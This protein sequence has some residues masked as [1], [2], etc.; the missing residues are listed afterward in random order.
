MRMMW[1][2]FL[3]RHQ[4][5]R[6][7]SHTPLPPHG[8]PSPIH[9][10]HPPDPLREPERLEQF[11]IDVDAVGVAAHALVHNLDVW[12]RLLVVRVVD[13]DVGAAEGVVVGVGGGEAEVGDGDD[14]FTGEGGYGAGGVGGVGGRGVVGHVAG[15]GGGEGDGDG[16]GE[17]GEGEG[18]GF[19]VCGWGLEGDLGCDLESD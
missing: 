4:T 12:V 6:L 11:D 15:V 3:Q 2:P 14:G 7:E 1:L 18:A 17:G 8:I 13:V 19:H 9:P 10:R 16:E 5:Q